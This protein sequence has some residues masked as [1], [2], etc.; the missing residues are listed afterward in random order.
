[1]T[2]SK[3]NSSCCMKHPTIDILLAVYNNEP[4][5]FEQLDS[6]MAQTYPHFH[7]IAR[8]DCS[9]DRSLEILKEF[10]DRYPNKMTVIKGT[11]NLG[12]KGNFAALLKQSEGGY[13][14]FC[15]ADDVWLPFKIEE[16]LALMQKNEA[17]YGKETPLLIHTD[18][19][20]T[21]KELKTLSHSFVHSSK[22]NPLLANQINRLLTQNCVTGCTVLANRA[23]INLASPI[24]AEAIMHDWWIALVASVFGHIDFLRKGTLY[25]RQHGKNDTGAKNWRKLSTYWQQ[26]KKEGIRGISKKLKKTYL[27]A[28]ALYQPLAENSHFD[29]ARQSQIDALH[30]E[31]GTPS[32]LGKGDEEDRFGKAAASQNG[33]FQLEAGIARVCAREKK[34][35]IIKEYSNIPNVNFLDKRIKFFR[36]KFFKH[37][38][39]KT[40]VSFFFL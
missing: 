2:W 22:L 32:P 19:I 40:F 9:T 26:F 7:I 13:V 14:M 12:A 6:L 37:T 15:D 28:E 35:A 21:D 5:L 33:N 25:Y 16:T 10:S 38:L 31:R 36:Y 29:S 20:V 30:S 11:E 1:M 23:L 24:P 39:E 27:Q 34:K 4:Y 8:D 17:I 3:T 18:L